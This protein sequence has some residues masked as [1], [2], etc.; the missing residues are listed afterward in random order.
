MKVREL[1][2]ELERYIKFGQADDAVLI[3]TQDPSVGAQSSVGIAGTSSGFDWDDGH[4]FIS[5]S[6]PLTSKPSR[7]LDSFS[8]VRQESGGIGF[9]A[10]PKCYMRVA[11]DD[12]Y[13]RY[14]GT[15]LAKPVKL[16]LPGAIGPGTGEMAPN[17]DEGATHE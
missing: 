13:C 4:V 12:S 15:K 8:V 16:P 17:G 3:K 7:Y 9:W 1:C 14:C 5:P 6:H 10:C 11:K 2:R